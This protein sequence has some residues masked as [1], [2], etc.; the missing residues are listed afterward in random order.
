MKSNLPHVRRLQ[1]LLSPAE[2]QV[3]D[4]E[5]ELVTVVFVSKTQEQ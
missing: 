4:G 2:S 1:Q 3:P 5:V